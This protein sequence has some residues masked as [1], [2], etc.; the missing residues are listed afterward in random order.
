MTHPDAFILFLRTLA[1]VPEEDAALILEAFEER[2]VPEGGELFLGGHVCRQLFFIVEGVLRIVVQNE[3]GV[4]VTHYFLKENQFCTILKSFTEEVVASESIQAAC[5]VRIRVILKRRL[6]DL[7][8]RLPYLR[9]VIDGVIQKG[10][11]EKIN[12]R[13]AYL[14]LDSAA[15]Y[16]LF[17]SRQPEIATRVSLTDVASYLEVTP[18]S[19]SRIRRKK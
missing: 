2:E 8:S 9:G 16:Q 18:Q 14:G 5:P 1:P 10:L 7:Y 19:L 17:L 6:L 4:D 11:I 13:N 3:K 15:R 12:T